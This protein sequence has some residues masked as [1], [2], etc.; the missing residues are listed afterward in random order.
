MSYNPWGKKNPILSM[1]LSGANALLGKTRS[2]MTASA[3][4]HTKAGMDEGTRQAL[5][6]WGLGARP[7]SRKRRRRR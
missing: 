1:W 2:E 7:A 6:F 3:R 4:R 5:E